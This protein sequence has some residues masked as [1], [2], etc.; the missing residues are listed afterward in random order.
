MAGLSVSVDPNFRAW[1]LG[2]QR[3]LWNAITEPSATTTR[4]LPAG[5]TARAH[6]ESHA[7]LLLR[8]CRTLA[9]PS[10]LR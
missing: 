6:A 1:T 7:R 3:M 9:L 8:P 2:T 10:A 4:A 5:A